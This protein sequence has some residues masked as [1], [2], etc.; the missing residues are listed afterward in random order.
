MELKNTAHV[1]QAFP[2][3]G[4]QVGLCL[5]AQCKNGCQIG[6][7]L[8]MPYDLPS[9]LHPSLPHFFCPSARHHT[10]AGI[11]MWEE[12]GPLPARCCSHARENPPPALTIDKEH[13]LFKIISYCYTWISGGLDTIKTLLS[14]WL[15]PSLLLCAW[16]EKD[17]FLLLARRGEV[18]RR[19]SLGGRV[20]G[21]E[22]AGK[23]L[24]MADVRVH[25]TMRAQPSSFF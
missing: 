21:G 2:V 10:C 1:V 7:E 12:Q 8:S 15:S 20:A 11:G 5:A 13:C 23:G 14:E 24:Q 17:F 4:G 6:K 16:A 18:R 22:R 9:L 3:A 19:K 25:K